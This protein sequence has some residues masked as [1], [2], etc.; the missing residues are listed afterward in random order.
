MDRKDGVVLC[1]FNR[2]KEKEKKITHLHLNMQFEVKVV[3]HLSMLKDLARAA[4]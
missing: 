3:F 2:K 4:G 1:H